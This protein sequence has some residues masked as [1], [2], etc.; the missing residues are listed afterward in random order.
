MISLKVA[1]PNQLLKAFKILF[2][3]TWFA[4]LLKSVTLSKYKMTETNT[5]S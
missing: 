5:I 1:A 3:Q 2:T 4:F